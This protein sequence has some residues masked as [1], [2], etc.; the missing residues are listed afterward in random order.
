LAEIAAQLGIARSTASNLLREERDRKRYL[1]EAEA[2]ASQ[3]KRGDTGD[4]KVSK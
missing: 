3:V 1:A 2:I 4:H